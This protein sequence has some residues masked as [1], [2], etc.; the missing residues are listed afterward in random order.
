MVGKGARSLYVTALVV[1]CT[2]L[3]G[4]VHMRQV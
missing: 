2:V 4:A 1:P 3:E